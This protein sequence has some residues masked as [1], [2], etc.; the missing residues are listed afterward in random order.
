MK[1]I[2][3]TRIDFIE[4][5]RQEPHTY[6]VKPGSPY[7]QLKNSSFNPREKKQN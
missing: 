4:D 7:C 1:F 5:L 3:I 6:T 2:K